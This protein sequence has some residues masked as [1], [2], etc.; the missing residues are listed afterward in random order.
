M[1]DQALREMRERA[2]RALNLPEHWSWL[3]AWQDRPTTIE[4]LALADELVAARE[5]LREW[6]N[7]RPGDPAT[8]DVRYADTRAF[9]GGEGKT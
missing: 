9:L 2:E 8:P 7:W 4:F 1:N 5:L 3:K 6:V